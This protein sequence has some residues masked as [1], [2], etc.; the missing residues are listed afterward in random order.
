MAKH[1]VPKK[2]QST[3]RTHRRYRTFQNLVRVR[4]TGAVRLVPCAKCSEPVRLHHLCES[5]G[6]YRG[7]DRTGQVKKAEEK[8]TKISA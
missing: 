1:P 8:V 2:K 6:H 3:T 7:K 4:L 5:C